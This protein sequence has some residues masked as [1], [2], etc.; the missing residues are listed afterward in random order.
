MHG[1]GWKVCV[2][3]GGML[4]WFLILNITWRQPQR[5]TNFKEYEHRG[6]QSQRKKAWNKNKIRWQRIT[7]KLIEQED[8][9]IWRWPC[10][11]WLYRKSITGRQDISE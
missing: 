7:R 11:R 4:W 9:F 1:T 8:D 10:V 5:K 6:R 3:C 2:W